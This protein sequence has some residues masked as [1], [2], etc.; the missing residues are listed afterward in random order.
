MNDIWTFFVAL[1]DGFRNALGDIN[2]LPIL[3][4]AMVIGLL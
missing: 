4:V 2:P 3:V 1:S